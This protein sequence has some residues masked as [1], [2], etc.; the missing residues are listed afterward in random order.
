[1][2]PLLLSLSL[3]SP[4]QVSEPAADPCS[5]VVLDLDG[6]ALAQEQQRLVP[7]I[8]ESLAQEVLEV[9]GC[10]VVSESDVKQLLELEVDK[11]RCGDESDSCLAEIGAAMG[12][13]RVVSGRVGQ[14]GEKFVV[15]ARLLD[16]T[17]AEVAMR[18]EQVVP[19]EEEQLRLAARNVARQ[20][21]GQS[22]LPLPQGAGGAAEVAEVEQEA[23]PSALLWGGLGLSVVGLGMGAAGGITAAIGES[24]LAESGYQDK[25]GARG[26][27]LL[28]LGAAG[29]GALLAVTGATLSAIWMLEE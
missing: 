29:A 6:A 18:G 5:V 13:E 2:L 10:K 24:Q 17:R 14:L 19:R 16:T 3:L 23:G 22:P 7:L 15:Q 26:L 8:S 25:E 4:H 27:G 9:S 12:A 1:L 21:F 11:Q 20:L 28:G